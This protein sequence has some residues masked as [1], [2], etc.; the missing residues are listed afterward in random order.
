MNDTARYGAAADV[1]SIGMVFWDMMMASGNTANPARTSW[2]RGQ[3]ETEQIWKYFR[4]FPADGIFDE[5][6]IDVKDFL[7]RCS[8]TLKMDSLL[9]APKDSR[10][11]LNEALHYQLE[12]DEWDLLRGLLR[13]NPSKRMTIAE[14]LAHP[15]FVNATVT[16]PFDLGRLPSEPL[17][18]SPPISCAFQGTEI[19][20]AMWTILLD[21]LYIV[22]QNMVIKMVGRRTT[23]FRFQPAS[24]FLGI[25][26]LRC[27]LADAKVHKIASLQMQG[28][29]A[30]WLGALYQEDVNTVPDASD[31]EYIMDHSKPASEIVEEQKKMFLAV[32]A[33]LHLPSSW[34]KLMELIEENYSENQINQISQ[35]QRKCMEECLIVIE[36]TPSSFDLTETQIAQLAYDVCLGG[37]GPLQSELA[38]KLMTDLTQMKKGPTKLIKLNGFVSLFNAISKTEQKTETEQKKRKE[39]NEVAVQERKVEL[40]P[41]LTQAPQRK[42]VLTARATATAGTVAPT[43]KTELVWKLSAAGMPATM[44]MSMEELLALWKQ[45]MV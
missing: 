32:G 44:A 42:A 5:V 7:A 37:G 24:L 28:A 9:A 40:P 36:S 21:W 27:Y 8:P 10:H 43:K 1:W 6:K 33:R 39:E 22:T 15:F 25:H 16:L 18:L 12:D 14:A 29:A 41:K 19:T 4:T 31:W 23:K 17:P 30:L 20:T 45:K 38:G 26:V 13:I 3:D 11:V 35:T 34:T 2:L